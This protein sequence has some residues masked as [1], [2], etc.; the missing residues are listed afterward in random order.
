MS[1]TRKVSI[2][3]EP[4]QLAALELAIA[5]GEYA[6]TDQIVREAIT[7]WQ[8]KRGLSRE[9]V[10]RLR[11]LWDAGKASGQPSKFDIE[12]TIAS[13]RKRLGKSAAE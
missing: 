11:H 5:S 3:L 4:E 8:L 13:A 1:D 12:R 6:T 9:D 7:D 10:Q 2:A